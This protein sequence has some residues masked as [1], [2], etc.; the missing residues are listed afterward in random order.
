MAAFDSLCYLAPAD[1]SPM[2]RFYWRVSIEW[3]NRYSESDEAGSGS[4]ADDQMP[5]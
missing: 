3:S 4:H 1:S 5:P 2:E